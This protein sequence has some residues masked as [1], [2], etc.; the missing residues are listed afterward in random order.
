MRI[1]VTGATGFVGSNLA[2]RLGSTRKDLHIRA[3]TRSAEKLKKKAWVLNMEIVEA[4]VMDC[5]NLTKALEG[6]DVAYYLI[7]SMEGSSPKE[8]K[9]FAGRDRKAAENFSKA[10]T[11]C[12]V[13]RIIYL[14]GLIHASEG[15]SGNT[16]SGN[17]SEHM[18]SRVEV[19]RILSTSSA[20]VTNIVRIAFSLNPG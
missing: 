3:I 2:S 12:K 5:P 15:L 20:K 4:D 18:K 13:D 11:E 6:C 9:K 16:K 8:W 19:G 14:G 7:H 17:M 10:A 1:L